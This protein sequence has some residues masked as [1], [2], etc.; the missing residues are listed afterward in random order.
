[1]G[2]GSGVAASYGIGHRCGSDPV[3]PRL[4]CRPAAVA[5]IQP[6]LQKLPNT[7][8]AVVKAKQRREEKRKERKG[9]ESN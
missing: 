5:L 4:W 7:I 6:L 9:K 1:M 8:D 3:L 2:K